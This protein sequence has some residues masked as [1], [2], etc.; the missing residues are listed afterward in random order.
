[1]LLGFLMTRLFPTQLIRLFN[2]DAEL[3]AFG[4]KAIGYWFFAF[5]VVG[6][7]IIASNF[8]QAIGRP[9]TAIFLTMTHQIIFL[10]PAILILPLFWGMNG[11]LAANAVAELLSAAITAV[12]YI[13][14]IRNLERDTCRI[15]ARIN[16][17]I[18][19][20]ACG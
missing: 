5:P 15:D 6:L 9:K 14:A 1:M 19:E 11:L 4:S 18:V 16:P 3:V 12:W 13:L 20:D 8:F 17:V 7:Q 2:Q 10:I